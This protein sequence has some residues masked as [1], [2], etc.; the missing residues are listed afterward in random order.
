MGLG[1]GR[2]LGLGVGHQPVEPVAEDLGVGVEQDDGAA[3]AEAEGAVDRSDEAEV[4]LVLDEVEQAAVRQGGQLRGELRV[5]GAVVDGEQGEGCGLRGRQAG[6]EGAQGLAAALVDWDDDEHAGLID[7]Q[8]P[9]QAVP[10]VRLGGVHR[11][12]G[13]EI[14]GRGHQA[15]GSPRAHVVQ[16]RR[17]PRRQQ[18]AVGPA[19]EPGREG[20]ARVAIL[21]LP[22]G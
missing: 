12:V 19:I 4:A 11:R 14:L 8:G 3:L 22:V 17:L 6:V 21:L 1:A 13:A 5:G 9:G 15:G 10:R 18:V 7:R 16:E 20:L 2:G